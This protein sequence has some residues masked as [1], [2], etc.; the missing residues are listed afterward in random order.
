MDQLLQVQSSQCSG[1]RQRHSRRDEHMGPFHAGGSLVRSKR[2]FGMGRKGGRR[3][4]W[5]RTSRRKD[6][7]FEGKLDFAE[8]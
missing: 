3:M 7:I 6:G 2:S 5:Q 4:T 8:L 1:E